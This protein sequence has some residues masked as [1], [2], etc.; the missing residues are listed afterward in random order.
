MDFLVW[1][2]VRLAFYPALWFNRLMCVLGLW[3]RWD[4]VD[5]NVA[6]GA[7]PSSADLRQLSAQGVAAVVNMCEEFGGDPRAL[8]ACGL[9]Q[10]H[11]PTLDYHC[12]SQEDLL[13]GLQFI[14]NQLATGRK[15]LLH[16]KA[17]RGRSAVL[18]LCYLMKSQGL[19][20]SEALTVL[21]ARRRQLAH[22]IDRHP[23]VHNI[24]ACVCS[25]KSG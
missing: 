5:E 14:D 2:C 9:T 10:L 11:L 19:S 12:P 18:A 8:R 24:E 7:L 20:A 6:V 17:G 3:H 13:R 15:V 21:K 4:W 23:A 22:G 16:C 25:L 1:L